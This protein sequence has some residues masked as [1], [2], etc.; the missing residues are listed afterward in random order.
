[1]RDQWDYLE[2]TRKIASEQ[3]V[4][5]D[6]S[7]YLMSCSTTL[8]AFAPTVYL[9]NNYTYFVCI[10]GAII[11]YSFNGGSRACWAS[12][13]ENRGESADA[14]DLVFDIIWEELKIWDG[15]GNL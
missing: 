11:F 12:G 13:W 4:T 9:F 7:S 2:G 14:K 3:S 10:H 15:V 6:C 5:I 8:F 1:M